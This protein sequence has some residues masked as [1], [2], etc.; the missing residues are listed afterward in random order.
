MVLPKGWMVTNAQ[1]PAVV[2]ETEDGRI[3]LDFDNPRTD[4][5]AVLITAKKVAP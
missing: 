1:V 3:R 5:V 4:E 2:S